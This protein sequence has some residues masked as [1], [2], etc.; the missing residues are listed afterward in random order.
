M[1]LYCCDFSDC[2]RVLDW[3]PDLLHSLLEWL[4]TLYSTLL[5]THT[6]T[7]TRA[8][9]HSH[10]FTAVAWLQDPKVDVPLRLGSLCVPGLNYQLLTVTAHSDWTAAILSLTH[11]PAN[12]P[13]H[14]PTPQS[15]SY[16][17]TGGLP[18]VSS[19]WCR[20][21]WGSWPEFFLQL[22]PC[23]YSSYVTYSLTRGL[24][25]L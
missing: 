13:T 8:N 17:T 18:P 24:V 12:W 22:N 6:H 19:P 7:N 16:F 3:L 10:V 4:T 15:Q 14:P 20:V 2:R 21:P 1:W 5:Q 9:V 25:Y 23:G 11:Q